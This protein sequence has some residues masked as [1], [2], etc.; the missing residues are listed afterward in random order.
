MSLLREGRP[1]LSVA[2]VADRSGVHRTTVYRWW[3]TRSDLL[4]EAL[5]LHTALLITPDEG[6]WAA[7]V[8]ALAHALAG[9]FSDPVE[10][11]MNATMASG[12][13]PEGDE[14]QVEHWTPV[15]RELS[16]IVERAKD[17][18]EIG[19]D[20]DAET[21]MYLLVSPLLMHTMLF[22]ARPDAPLV[23]HLADAVTRAFAAAR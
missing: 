11:A 2:E 17:R 10:M 5:T 22:H 4:R 12:A 3:P 13:D 6:S 18:G 14:V 8:S 21:V 7:D 19:H 23:R 15:V 9:F 16:Q 1:Q 20:T